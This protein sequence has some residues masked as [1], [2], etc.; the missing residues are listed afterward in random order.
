MYEFLELHNKALFY[1]KPACIEGYY[2]FFRFFGRWSFSHHK[3]YYVQHSLGSEIWTHATGVLL[4]IFIPS[5]L[6]CSP[7][8][9]P[10]KNQQYFIRTTSTI[11][12]PKWMSGQPWSYLE[13]RALGT[14]LLSLEFICIGIKFFQ[15]QHAYCIL[16][17]SRGKR[18]SESQMTR[19]N[20]FV[21]DNQKE[22]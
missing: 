8:G 7:M 3:W 20:I 11:V 18:K 4:A 13:D 21:H 12:W 17:T 2:S 5:I 19:K 15:W 16:Y 22:L 6:R 1:T 10:I 14:L 9:K